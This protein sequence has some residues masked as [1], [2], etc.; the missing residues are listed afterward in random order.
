VQT[1]IP[2]RQIWPVNPHLPQFI[3]DR[4]ASTSMFDEAFAASV[5]TQSNTET[6][7]RPVRSLA[8]PGL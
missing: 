2:A 7:I 6:V 4:A 5:G 3:D 1:E 8:D